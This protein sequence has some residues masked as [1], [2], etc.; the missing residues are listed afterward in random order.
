MKKNNDLQRSEDLTGSTGYQ[1]YKAIEGIDD[2]LILLGI[3]EDSWHFS[4]RQRRW[5]IPVVCF[6]VLLA[7][8]L[9]LPKALFNSGVVRLPYEH[10]VRLVSPQQ[11]NSM[12][13]EGVVAL[14]KILRDTALLPEKLNIVYFSAQVSRKGII[15][16]FDLV[17][18]SY[19]KLGQFSGKYR[20]QY[21]YSHKQM[22]FS[23]QDTS[24]A[25]I[26]AVATPFI[27]NDNFDISHIFGQIGR[28]PLK[29]QIDVL[30]K[31]HKYDRYILYFAFDRTLPESHPI[32]DG[33]QIAAIPVLTPE[34][35]QKGLGGTSN[36][37]PAMYMDLYDGNNLY[38]GENRFTYKLAPANP[39]ALTPLVRFTMK[40][41]YRI[42][43][44]T[45]QLT[46]DYGRTWIDVDIPEEDVR[47]TM[48]FYRSNYFIPEDSYFISEDP[49]GVV[50]FIYGE[51]PKLRLSLDDGTTWQTVSFDLSHNPEQSIPGLLMPNRIVGFTGALDGYVGLGSTWTMGTGEMK[52]AYFTHDGG[53]TW[54]RKTLPLGGTSSTLTGM[55]FADDNNGV[56][57]LMSPH[58]IYYDAVPELFYTTDNGDS[59]IPFELPQDAFQRRNI[60]EDYV[61]CLSRVDSLTYENGIF[62]LVCGVGSN[63][64]IR[65]RFQSHSLDGPWDFVESYKAAV[66][67]VG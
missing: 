19:D 34:D 65:A 5:G 9:I 22:T 1:L 55:V 12:E 18:Y 53:E 38:S 11:S 7:I 61:E 20:F 23:F 39:A 3:R 44:N 64:S 66:H 45:I 35:Y 16:D 29:Q 33:S 42:D 63:D 6:C 25:V 4:F 37:A 50:A 43:R 31:L 47:E 62:T 60:G 27:Y 51:T 21:D 46:R 26:D 28:I 54:T 58:R 49:G 32:I 8:G 10:E 67:T 52:Y 56:L 30:E 17:L 24:Q 40:C 59:W 13:K 57:S 48:V 36:S 14:E 15:E 2:D 41:D